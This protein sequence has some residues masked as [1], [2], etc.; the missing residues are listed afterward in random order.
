MIGKELFTRWSNGSLKQAKYLS[1]RQMTPYPRLQ[2]HCALNWIQSRFINR[3][4]LTLLKVR[5]IA[6][7]SI[8]FLAKGAVSS[9]HLSHPPVGFVSIDASTGPSREPL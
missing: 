6:A 2:T 1:D 4:V 9:T 3:F 8:G 7:R 5:Q